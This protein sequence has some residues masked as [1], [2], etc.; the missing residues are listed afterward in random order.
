MDKGV[1][2]HHLRREEVAKGRK[3]AID[4][5]LLRVMQMGI[6]AP[7]ALWHTAQ[8][9]DP[10]LRGVVQGRRVIATCESA[11]GVAVPRHGSSV[12]CQL[13]VI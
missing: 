1:G 5:L 9:L 13:G 11:A 3:T 2:M 8:D 4:Y 10:E 12:C 6:D 7:A